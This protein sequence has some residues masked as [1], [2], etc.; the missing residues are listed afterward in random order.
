MLPVIKVKMNTL[1]F[2]EGNHDRKM[3]IVL[4]GSVSLFVTRQKKDVEL[5]VIE[6]HGFFGETEMHRNRPRAVSAKALVDTRLAVIK[7][8]WQLEQ[9]ISANPAFSAKM[10]RI[11]GER[12]ATINAS[13]V[14][15]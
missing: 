2:E 15:A 14:E 11:M 5:A 6:K 12:L 9:F 1:I 3:F 10:T 13:L 4:D 8:R 7:T